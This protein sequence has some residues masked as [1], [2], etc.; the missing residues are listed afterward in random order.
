MDTILETKNLCH[1]E[2]SQESEVSQ[3]LQNRDSSLHAT[4]FA[5]NDKEI[6]CHEKSNDFSCNDKKSCNDEI[7]KL[8]SKIDN[9]VYTLY[10]LDSNE[11]QIVESKS[12]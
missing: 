12:H 1:T 6:D 10:A 3:K 9:L 8:Q 4:R 11:I 7:T 5:Q 2:L